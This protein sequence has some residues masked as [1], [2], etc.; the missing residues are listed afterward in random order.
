M[1]LPFLG[2][3]PELERLRRAFRR[4]SGS[5]VVLYGR[6][7]LGKS[8]L[9]VESLATEA[10]VYYVGDDRDEALQR[11]SLAREISRLIPHFDDVTYPDWDAL[12]ER[13]WKDAPPR[14]ILALDEFPQLV[15]RSPSLPSLLQ[16]LIDR[17]GK[18]ARHVALS[19]S[20]QRMMHGLVLDA[21]APLF[22][23]A[24]EILRIQPLGARWLRQG[25]RLRSAASTMDHWAAWGG[26]PR[27]W[28]L[29]SEHDGRA[30]AMK[31]LA[32]DPLGVLHLEPERLLLD[33]LTEITRASSLLSLVGRGAHRVSEISGRIGIPST[34]LSRPLSMLVDLGLLER[35][36][37]WGRSPRDSKRSLY[38]IADPFLRTWFRF[39]EPA[40][41]RLE[42]G[43]I[44]PVA[45]DIE[46]RWS[47]HL[48][49]SWEDIARQSVAH[50]DIHGHRWEPA[51]RWWGPGL[52]RKPLE[53]DIV[54][55][56]RGDPDLMLCGE[57]KVAANAADV[58][59][60]LLELRD[61]AARCPP[62]RGHRVMFAIWALNGPRGR[63]RPD[64]L[65]AAAVVDGGPE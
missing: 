12:L 64:V 30:A 27:Y 45:A 44:D 63:R 57:A 34:S 31:H 50:L 60:Q 62:L 10:A 49:E 58:D 28:E 2:R 61:R 19:G 15:Q 35:E 23:R 6:R 55:K 46:S 18:P 56:S 3:A 21:T 20:S 65:D 7:R 38:R 24:R 4:H 41:S 11:E 5:L 33:D 16:K 1:R 26:V 48:G 29:A 9:L 59:R 42:A 39:I 47:H 17:D 43:Q 8:R 32:L 53:I 14:S 36:S 54:A 13:W 25:L 37:P 51:A 40:R 52:D 22:G